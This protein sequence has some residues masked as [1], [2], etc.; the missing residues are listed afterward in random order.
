MGNGAVSVGER[1]S[2]PLF[3]VV[4]PSYNQGRYIRDCI[5]SVLQQTEVTWEHIVIDGGSTDDTIEILKQY[6]HLQ[7]ISEPDRGMSD[8]INK[9]FLRAKGRWVMWLNTDDYLLPGALKK[10][11]EFAEAH[12]EA[13]VI[14]GYSYFVDES[15][16]ILREKC[17]HKFDFLSLLFVGCYIQSTATF[18]KRDIIQ[19]GH[20][21]N[22][23]FRYT[24]DYDYYMRL[25]LAGYKFLYL[26]EPLACFRW[27][28]DNLSILGGRSG[29][30]WKESCKVKEYAL[31]QLGY[32]WLA[33][34]FIFK[35]MFYLFRPRRCL[36]RFRAHGRLL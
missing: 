26:P 3:T 2:V 33:N 21:L 15:K 23:E 7:W 11:A 19:A 18:I 27:H 8:A 17:E 16:R 10:V 30:R 4:T 31:Q 9:G 29:A 36:L 34:P 6:P 13:D 20:L 25:A 22:I 12:P 28:G 24:M 14:Y 35:A 5:E 1:L 32:A